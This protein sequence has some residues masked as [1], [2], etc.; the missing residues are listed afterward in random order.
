MATIYLRGERFYVDDDMVER[1]EALTWNPR[2][3]KGVQRTYREDGKVQTQSLAEF[4]TGEKAGKGYTWVAEDENWRNFRRE[5][6]V[7]KP[8]GWKLAEGREER[9]FKD[10]DVRNRQ[11]RTNP[12]GYVGVNKAGNKFRAVATVNGKQ[13]YLGLYATKEEAA[14]AYDAALIAQ[15]LPPVNLPPDGPSPLETR[16]ERV[17][18]Q[19][20]ARLHELRAE[21]A[22]LEAELAAPP[23]QEPE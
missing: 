8:R 12:T 15:G 9:L 23:R 10:G 2:P 20:E 19:K 17:R 18:Q 14:R 1:V 21:V 13:K 22:R 5:N 11:T 6:L 7:L 16:Q 3:G 4:I